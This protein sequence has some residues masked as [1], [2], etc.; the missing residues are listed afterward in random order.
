MC[1]GEGLVYFVGCCGDVE[2]LSWNGKSKSVILILFFSRTPL[3]TAF[4]KSI[5]FSWLAKTGKS[6]C[7]VPTRSWG[8]KRS[9]ISR[10]NRD[11]PDPLNQ[12]KLSLT[13]LKCNILE[14]DTS[15]QSF[16]FSTINFENNTSPEK[17]GDV[18]GNLDPTPL[19]LGKCGSWMTKQRP[20]PQSIRGIWC[21]FSADDLLI[22]GKMKT[23]LFSSKS[24]KRLYF[25]SILKT[26]TYRETESVLSPPNKL[27][28]QW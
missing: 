3:V 19:L 2:W 5:C 22:E 17:T 4:L 16:E 15:F 8:W 28:F 10:E 13:S 6:S 12:L 23:Q 26:C 11:A 18:E 27:G 14:L 24:V 1:N 20:R 9:L 25:S 21:P 7:F